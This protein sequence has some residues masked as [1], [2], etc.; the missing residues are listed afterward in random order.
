MERPSYSN[1]WRPKVSKIG[2]S[3]GPREIPPKQGNMRETAKKSSHNE[4]INALQEVEGLSK[5]FDWTKGP[6]G[7]IPKFLN[8]VVQT[9]SRHQR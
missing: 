4:K 1:Y 9:I 5:S 2:P 8:T 6:V 3:G 7:K